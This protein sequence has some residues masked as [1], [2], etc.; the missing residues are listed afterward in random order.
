MS[1][2]LVLSVWVGWQCD[3]NVTVMRALTESSFSFHHLLQSLVY[4]CL[5]P[6]PKVIILLGNVR[7]MAAEA[8]G[9][10]RCF[11]I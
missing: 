7:Y 9:D 8:S 4:I 6:R 11:I 1:V 10:S 3:S 5:S 2:I